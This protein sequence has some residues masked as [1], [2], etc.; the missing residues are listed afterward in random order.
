MRLGLGW[1][2]VPPLAYILGVGFMYGR[3][4]SNVENYYIHLGMGWA[5]WTLTSRVVNGSTKAFSSYKSFIMDGQT[6]YTDFVLRVLAHGMFSFSFA[7][8]V[9]FVL[10]MV[11]PS[12]H[13]MN[14][15]TLFG[16]LPVYIFNIA[17]VGMLLAMLG[18][19]YPDV[20]E[21]IGTLLM[22]GF[23]LSPILWSASDLPAGT[24]RGDLAR[25]NPVF[26]FI[27]FVRAPVMGQSVP[28]ASY[29][30]VGGMT[31][32]GWLITSLAYRRYARFIPLWA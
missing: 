30:V 15:L 1:A 18:A 32:G 27:E 29:M 26:H 28:T 9:V 10:L 25:L 22:F 21:F 31:L 11:N 14:M 3:M 17:W 19:R 12:I 5:L 13:W 16:T 4:F 6:R 23:F 8:A 20:R 2:L 24:L 7:S